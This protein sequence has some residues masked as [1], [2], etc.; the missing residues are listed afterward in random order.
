MNRG[1]RRCRDLSSYWSSRFDTTG[2]CVRCPWT[3]HSFLLVVPV[4]N[5]I[6]IHNKPRFFYKKAVCCYCL[7]Q[8]KTF[9]LVQNKHIIPYTLI[10]WLFQQKL[11][12]D[13]KIAWF[14]LFLVMMFPTWFWRPIKFVNKITITENYPYL[15]ALMNLLLRRSYYAIMDK[16][17][18]HAIW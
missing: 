7:L 5:N 4:I 14:I 15:Y 8:V 3:W 13:G 10:L 9:F 17:L 6:I 18:N 16:R 2:G 1:R 12:I 11:F